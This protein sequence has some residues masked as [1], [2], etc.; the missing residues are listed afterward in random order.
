ME[1]LF[2]E[3]FLRPQI[4]GAR[5]LARS[6]G[7]HLPDAGTY[8]ESWEISAHPLHY[9][10]VSEGTFQGE[11]LPNLWRKYGNEIFGRTPNSPVAPETFPLLIKYLDCNQL[12]SVQVHPNDAMAKKLSSE[13][14]GKAEAWVVLAA[15]PQ[16]RIFAGLRDGVTRG[17][18]ESRMEDGTVAECLYEIAPRLGECYMFKAGTVHA[19]GG[20]VLVAEIQQS[21]DAT[22]R[23]F[24]WN[25]I[26][27][28]GKPRKLHREEAL[29][30]IDWELGPIHPVRPESIAVKGTGVK[31]SHLTNCEFFSLSRYQIQNGDMPIPFGDQMSIW[32]VLSGEATLSSPNGYYRV[33]RTGATCL[34]PAGFSALKWSAS[35]AELLATVVP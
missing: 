22:F 32:M 6:L 26:G 20:G 12:L 29:Q 8:G 11:S 25:R 9:S 5:E 16:S 10:S 28:D 17:E 23:L 35:E 21:S 24:D 33:C 4:W 13:G 14:Q 18:L 2:F 3:P 19:A 7:K 1:P 15:E 27:T 31:G 30:A 34:I